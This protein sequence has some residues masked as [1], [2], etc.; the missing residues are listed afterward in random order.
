[1]FNTH[2]AFEHG[3]L[4]TAAIQ[5]DIEC[6]PDRNETPAVGFHHERSVVI[7]RHFE[8]RL[9]ADEMNIALRSGEL[10]IELRARVERDLRTV[11]QGDIESLSCRC[12]IMARAVPADRCAQPRERS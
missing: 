5:S 8:Q 9:A 11:F 2:G 1:M 10:Y 12:R 4:D 3:Q 7:V 6:R